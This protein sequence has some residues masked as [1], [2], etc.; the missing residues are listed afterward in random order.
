MKKKFL[1]IT[2]TLLI[3]MINFSGCL[4][5][6]KDNFNDINGDSD[7]EQG[8]DGNLY[9]ASWNLQI[10]GQSKASNETLLNYYADRLD[11]YDI[12]I[13]QEIRDA[14]GTAIQTFAEKFPE[15]EYVISNRAG[16]SSSKEQYAVFYNGRATLIDFHDYQLEYQ[17]DMQR[18]PLRITFTSNN[19]TFT[20]YTIHIQPDNV[21]G[22]LSILETIVGEPSVDTIIL[23][24][25][26]ADGDYYDEENIIHFTDW[27]WSISNDLDTTVAA[28]DN[29]YDRIIFNDATKNNYYSMGVMDDV[30]KDQSDHYLVYAIF[31]T[32]VF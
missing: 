29:T 24:D 31:N 3:I 16:Q 28:S 8:G 25:F 7:N 5:N 22:E 13:I 17:Q 14:S 4:D 19:W 12:F 15:Y 27:I 26:N 32:E 20:I 11:E 6:I 9:I 21:A 18:P 2:I 10:F 30:T 1:I 23:G